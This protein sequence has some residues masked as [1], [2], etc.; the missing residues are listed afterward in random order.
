M[1]L[2][3]NTRRKILVGAAVLGQIQQRQ[4]PEAKVRAGLAASL[5]RPNDRAL[6]EF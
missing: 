3:V 2:P 1:D 4:F 5:V 6:T